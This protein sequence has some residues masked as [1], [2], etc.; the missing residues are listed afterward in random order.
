MLPNIRVTLKAYRKCAQDL[1]PV[2]DTSQSEMENWG[3][4]AQ[5]RTPKTG[6]YILPSNKKGTSLVHNSKQH[7]K[8]ER[9]LGRRVGAPNIAIYA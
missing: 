6:L 4:K 2:T 5:N 1:I 3:K 7:K 9:N 8:A